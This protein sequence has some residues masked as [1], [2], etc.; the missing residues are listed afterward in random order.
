M[1]RYRK[2]AIISLVVILIG[3]V[4][5]QSN[6]AGE[7]CIVDP[8][9]STQTIREISV[10]DAKIMI[11]NRV[12]SDEFM[13]LDIRTPEEFSMGFIDGAI[14]LDYYSERFESEVMEFDRNGTYMIYCQSATRTTDTGMLMAESGFREVYLLD[15]GIHSW[16]EAGYPTS[17]L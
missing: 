13:L 17:Q 3:V 6:S 11:Q 9:L 7:N 1:N 12:G 16:E 15:G 14:N 2:A 5:Y 10:S 8:S 4:A